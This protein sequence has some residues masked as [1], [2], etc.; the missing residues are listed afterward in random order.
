V[1]W[2]RDTLRQIKTIYRAKTRALKKEHS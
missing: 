2:D 1:K